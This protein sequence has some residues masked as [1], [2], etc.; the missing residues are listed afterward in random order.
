MKFV[1]GQQD[2]VNSVYNSPARII[3]SA[4]IATGMYNSIQF[5]LDSINFRAQNYLS[6]LSVCGY[7]AAG[8]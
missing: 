6:C 4:R 1:F 3:V 5:N 2:F 7:N 8:E